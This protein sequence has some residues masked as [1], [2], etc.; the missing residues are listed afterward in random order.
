MRAKCCRAVVCETAQIFSGQNSAKFYFPMQNCTN[1]QCSNGCANNW[2][3]GDQNLL[4]KSF[5]FLMQ[6]RLVSSSFIFMHDALGDHFVDQW[7][8]LGKRSACGRG[9]FG[10]DGCIY[11]LDVGSDHGTLAGV[12]NASSFRLTRAFACL[13]TISQRI[14]PLRGL[15]FKGGKYAVAARRCQ[16]KSLWRDQCRR[17]WV[18]LA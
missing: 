2:R 10:H 9:V 6:T 14:P 15:I 17:I 5:Y 18:I 8:C 3:T 13:W 7:H 12:L 16:L 11:S 4:G 1:H